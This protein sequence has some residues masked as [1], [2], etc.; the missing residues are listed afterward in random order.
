MQNMQPQKEPYTIKREMFL[1]GFIFLIFTSLLFSGIFLCVVYRSNLK[2]ARASLCEC[3]NQMTTYTEGIFHENAMIVEILARNDTVIH[4]GNGSFEAV[5][6]EF[7]PILEANDNIT[8]IYSGYADGSLLIDGYATPL[9][10]DAT[11][12][13]WYLAAAAT[14]DVAKLV[15]SDAAT[16]ACLFSQCKRL[17]DESGEM[18][19]AVAID[20]SNESLSKQL[21]TKYSYASQRSF[22]VDPTGA[23]LLHPDETQINV[24]LREKMDAATWGNIVAGRS[25]YAEYV[26]DDLRTMAYLER[27]PNTDFI[28]VTAISSKE[29]LTPILHSMVGLLLL[30]VV[31]SIA[32]GALL[33][34]ILIRRFARPI[35]EL[36]QRIQCIAAGNAVPA[37]GILT[38]NAEIEDIAKSIEIIVADIAAS[39]K[40]RKKAEYLSFHDS[41]TGLYNRRFFE[42]EL[43]R[44]D[45]RRNYPLCLVC[46]DVNGLKLV[47]DLF[48]HAVGDRLIAA[49]ADALETGCRADD[50]LARIGGD[51]FAIILPRTSPQDA[52]QMM[53]R[54]KAGLPKERVFGAKVSVSLGYAVKSD[55]EQSVEDVLR[56]ADEMMYQEKLLESMIMKQDTI[57]GLFETA[58]EEGLLAELSQQ[59]QRLLDAFAHRLCPNVCL[60]LKESY[61]LRKIGLCS[62]LSSKPTDDD[63]LYTEAGYRVLSQLDDTR[64]YASFVLYYRER[65][66][67]S[68][69]PAGLVGENIPLPSRIM[70]VVEAVMEYP[71]SLGQNP[72]W[73]D[74][75]LL[76]LL[77]DFPLG[78]IVPPPPGALSSAP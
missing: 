28:V 54:L 13:P 49:I 1:I 67:G 14:Q 44:L 71:S 70:A 39:E 24:S 36:G 40:Q 23:V 47:N 18:V 2:S 48:G 15:Y 62:L 76:T 19:G 30:T 65:F 35:V 26:T 22:I 12:R 11:E 77:K 33:S 17:V 63:Q 52:A 45:V 20:C 31:L 27:I 4:A 8:Y 53:R 61:R 34:R 58:K 55:R 51:E 57:M 29:I 66:D 25:N 64:P 78:S 75:A 37:A 56:S 46:C 32:L 10:F 38:S 43:R 74:P 72:Q 68:G 9:D 60:P 59:E 69:R 50:I 6:A 42:E 16:G 7:H 41:M 21:S 5:L 73:Y 3:N